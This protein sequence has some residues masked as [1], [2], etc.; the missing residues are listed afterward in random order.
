MFLPLWT[1]AQNLTNTSI[2]NI[3]KTWEQEPEGYTYP[4][5][6]KVPT[7]TMPEHG[8]PV[9]VLLHGNGGNGVGAVAQYANILACHVLIAPT[10]YQN[11][12]NI[13]TENSDAP[14]I[15]MIDELVNLIQ[16][17]SNINPNQIRILGSSNGGSLANRVFVENTNAGIDAV[18]A[19]ISQ[20]NEN[21]YHDNEFYQPS[22]SSTDA[23]EAY[24]GYNDL[25]TPL[26]NRRYLSICNDNDPIIPYDGGTSVVGVDFLPAETAAYRIAEYLGYSDEQL[27]T[28]TTGGDPAITEFAYLYGKVIHV[29]GDAGH[30]MNATQHDYV[31]NFFSDCSV[32][33]G[34][35]DN[36]LDEAKVYPNPA[37]DNITIERNSGQEISYSII[38]TLGQTVVNN[39]STSE[40]INIDLSNLDPSVYFLKMDKQTIKIIKR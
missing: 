16:G 9:C 28:G 7:G 18:C 15:E 8:F 29:V 5:A 13:C 2:L 23:S 30:G 36:Q 34:V 33:S 4:V 10:G 21:Q 14:D 1:V 35:E 6:I 12:W 27:T 22:T 38:N 39:S 32:V 19:V 3:T 24:C 40:I 20:L 37:R 26:I 17:Y 25:V 11:S 31:K